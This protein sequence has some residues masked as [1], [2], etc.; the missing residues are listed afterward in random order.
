MLG[1]VLNTSTAVDRTVDVHHVR[2][3]LD[4][5]RRLAEIPAQ[6]Q[7]RGWYFKQTAD[8]VARQGRAA[9]AIYRR[10]TPIKTTWFFRMYSVRDYLEDAA[11][12]AAAINPADP[13]QAVREMWRGAPR[14]ASLFNHQRFF[15]LLNATPY[16]VIRH[17]EAQR[18]MFFSYGGWRLERL[19]ERHFVMHYFDEYIWIESAHRG[20]IEGVL[21]ACSVTGSVDPDLDSPFNGRIHVRWQPR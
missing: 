1:S 8:A 7:V 12:G 16:D 14:Y 10:L 20:G 11:A 19:E 3:A 6:A 2:R 15:T 5:D 18:D 13:H 9:V 17:L 21:H 4:L